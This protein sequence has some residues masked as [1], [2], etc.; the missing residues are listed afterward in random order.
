MHRDP[1]DRLLIAQAKT[2]NMNFLTHDSQLS[3]YKENCIVLV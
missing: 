3:G 1:F 2:G